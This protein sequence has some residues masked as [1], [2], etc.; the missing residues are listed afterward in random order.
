MRNLL[1][2][3]LLAPS[4][5]LAQVP[6]YVPTNGLVAWYPM[7]GNALDESGNGYDCQSIGATLTED[8]FGAPS[9]A[10][11]FDGQ[12]SHLQGVSLPF[13]DLS[14]SLWFKAEAGVFE[15]YSGGSP[16]TGAQLIGQGTS[17]NPCRY[18]DWAI[19]ISDWSDGVDNLAWEKANSSPCQ[20]QQTVSNWE[21]ELE[22]WTHLAAVSEGTD[23]SF[24][25]NGNWV[26]S[27]PFD[28]PF[29]QGGSILSIGSRYVENCNG[30]GSCTGPDNAWSGSI[31]DVAVWNRALT[32]DEVQA[33]FIGMPPVNGCTDP[34]ACN[35]D[36]TATEDDGSCIVDF[37]ISNL[38]GTND[39]QVC[40]GEE[41]IL[42]L[43]SAAINGAAGCA[44]NP[45]II[46]DESIYK[47]DTTF[48]IAVRFTLNQSDLYQNIYRQISDGEVNLVYSPTNGLSFKTK[49][50][51]GNCYTASGWVG[52]STPI[53]EGIQYSIVATYHRGESI[54]LFVDG[55]LK[56]TSSVNDGLL[57]DCN[58]YPND[59]G[60]DNDNAITIDEIGFYNSMLNDSSISDY[61]GC[62]IQ[63][64]LFGDALTLLE[65]NSNEIE[66]SGTSD[67]TIASATIDSIESSCSCGHP[68]FN[69]A[70][71]S[72]GLSSSSLTWSAA[73]DSAIISVILPD[74]PSCTD[75]IALTLYDA[76]A[77]A[78]PLACNFD[79]SAFCS[80][81]CTYPPFG[82]DNCITGASLCGE[83]TIWNST[84]QQCV[85]VIQT[86]DSIVV[87]IP[88]CGEGTV[89]DPVN[90]ECII[91]IPADLNYDGCVTVNDLLVLLAVHG[92]CPPYPEWPDEPNDT[93]WTCGD[94]LTYWDYDYATVLIGDQC[95]FAENL[96]TTVYVNG[97][98]IPAGLTGGEWNSTTGGA[99]AFY[100]NDA[101]SLE[102]FGRLYNWYAVN[103]MRGLCPSDW[104]VPSDEEFMTLEMELG[105]SETDA[106]SIGWYRGTDEGAQL[107]ASASDSPSWNGTNTSGFHGLSGGQRFGGGNFGDDPFCLWWSGTDSSGSAWSRILSS[108][109]LTVKRDLVPSNHGL[110]VRC[111]KDAE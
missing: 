72:T 79:S 53:E 5:L 69:Q 62:V 4:A 47:Q 76:T 37:S 66:T 7:N 12:G 52:V 11:A 99:T 31:D 58:L 96:R 43:Q 105:M 30:G 110:S 70:I 29:Q 81:N 83:N 89:W 103:D 85:G 86:P 71:W 98:L 92:T 55:E 42:N 84:L 95:W 27:I 94:S 16:P 48:S 22:E 61:T 1:A 51:Y 17:H 25:I 102:D 34:A 67:I 3:L 19:G 36:S 77:C 91:A 100:A 74:Y 20:V 14:I 65:F 107:K 104:H 35:Y 33:L 64:N 21:P 78:D 90:E 56:A 13:S 50:S 93:T 80:L 46:F 73:T 57:A 75:T 9:S 10:Y 6:N 63:S 59:I 24:Y 88:S 97:D 23:V 109:Y 68:A 41:V 108:T 87:L 49:A 26:S 39:L 101:S 44:V 18:C 111:L 40:P 2:L 106:N 28:Q 15:T 60:Q 54:R 45:F 82:L 38:N 8:R 32:E